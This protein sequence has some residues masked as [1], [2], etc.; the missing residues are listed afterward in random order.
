MII[1]YISIREAVLQRRPFLTMKANGKITAQ[2][3]RTVCARGEAESL[4]A[5]RKL[6]MN[7]M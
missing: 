2:Y 4:R 6:E 1:I 3:N 5:A 7:D